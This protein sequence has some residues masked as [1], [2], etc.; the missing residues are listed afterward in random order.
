M[1]TMSSRIVASPAAVESLFAKLEIL[2][3]ED[4]AWHRLVRASQRARGRY[5]QVQSPDARG[6]YHG[7]LTGYAVAVKALEGRLTPPR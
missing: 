3:G 5:E 1:R 7:L 2:A 4:P 6:F